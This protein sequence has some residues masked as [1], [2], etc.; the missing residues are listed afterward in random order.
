MGAGI[1]KLLATNGIPVDL[2]EVN[3]DLVRAG[4]TKIETL[5]SEAVRKGALTRDRADAALRAITPS[6]SWQ[7]MAGV[8]LAIEAV[9]EVEDVKSDVFRRLA[10]CLGPSAVLA[11]N[12]SAL[13]I[14]RLADST[15]HPERVAGLH[16]FNPVHKMHLVEVVRA[17]ATND[18]TI[19]LLV[20]LVRK[21]GKTPVVVADSPGFLVNRVLFP[22]LDEA[23]R[24]TIESGAGQRVNEEAVRFGMPI[25]PLELLDQ[26]GIDIAADVARTVAVLSADA[27]PTPNRL[28][29]MVKDGAL[30]KK[31]G[32]GFFTYEKEDKRGKPTRWAGNGKSVQTHQTSSNGELS[33]IQKRLFYPMINEAAKCLEAG[34]VTDPWVID[35]AMVLGI[36]FAPFRGGPLRLADSLGLDRVVSELDDL[37]RA[38]SPL[39]ACVASPRQSD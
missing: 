31:A 9:V 20:E 24:L 17:P 1:A 23:V 18:E 10:E 7:P 32:R 21:L 30:G 2:K 26:V 3:D 15:P 38:W 35:L 19:A 37:R 13:S 5:T 29:E 34:V 27:G 12:T 28:A 14:K 33:A 6:T 4:M 25:G 36:G 8:D 22:Y 11:S 16:F 39:R